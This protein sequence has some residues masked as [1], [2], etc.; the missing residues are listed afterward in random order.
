[1]SLAKPAVQ[2]FL[3]AR[4][5]FKVFFSSDYQLKTGQ[6]NLANAVVPESLPE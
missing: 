1:L 5:D 2:M 3:N 6:K 4:V